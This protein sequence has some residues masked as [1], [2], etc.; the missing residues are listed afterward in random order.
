[1][2]VDY[3]GYLYALAITIGKVLKIIQMHDWWGG[4]AS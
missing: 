4:G 2:G 1:M 3:L